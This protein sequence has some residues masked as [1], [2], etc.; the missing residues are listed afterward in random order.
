MQPV[1]VCPKFSTGDLLNG[2][3]ELQ[4]LMYI[5]GPANALLAWGQQP[6]MTN[7]KLAL[8]YNLLSVRSFIII[9]H[10]ILKL[11]DI[12]FDLPNMHL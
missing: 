11:K 4:L 12:G 9:S 1:C 7:W 8:D 5:Y 3:P 6:G 2:H 10:Q